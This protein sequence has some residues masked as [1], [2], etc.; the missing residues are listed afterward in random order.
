M[1]LIA[2]MMPFEAGDI[3]RVAIPHVETDRMRFRPA[4]VVSKSPMGPECDLI[5]AMMITNIERVGWR[6][7]VALRNH[8][9]LGL[10]IPSKVRTEKIATLESAGAVRIGKI[11]KATFAVIQ[12]SMRQYLG[13]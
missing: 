12:E 7:D 6:G 9:K 5:W 1:N 2:A 4:L 10:P 3:I 11:D 13:L 8:E